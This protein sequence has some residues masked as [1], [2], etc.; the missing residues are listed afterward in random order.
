MEFVF[1]LSFL[2][3]VLTYSSIYTLKCH[4]FEGFLDILIM[5]KL[6]CSSLQHQ[7]RKCGTEFQYFYLLFQLCFA[8]LVLFSW[9]HDAS[10]GSWRSEQLSFK[11]A[12][13]RGYWCTTELWWAPH[14]GDSL[15]FDKYICTIYSFKS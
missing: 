5:F 2:V 11:I 10:N 15:S 8:L 14:T 7:S 13:N 6:N 4:G 1:Y 9:R 3:S 12:G